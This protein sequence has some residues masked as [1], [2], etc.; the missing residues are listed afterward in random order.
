M[1]R[2]LSNYFDLRDRQATRRGKKMQARKT[3]SRFSGLHFFA[4]SYTDSQLI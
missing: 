2:I 4:G 3:R 1:L